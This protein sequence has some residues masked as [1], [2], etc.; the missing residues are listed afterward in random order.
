MMQF[1]RVAV[2]DIGRPGEEGIRIRNN[3]ISFNVVKTDAPDANALKVEIFNLSPETRAQVESTENRLVLSAGYAQDTIKV[4]AVGDVTSFYTESNG[5]G[6]MITV[7]E[8]GDGIRALTDTRVS[9][10]YEDGIAA[11]DIVTDIAD[12]LGVDA[13]DNLA[14]LTGTYRNGYTFAGQAKQGLDELAKRFDF[15]WS[16]QNSILQLL[17]RRTA[18]EREVVVLS[19]ETGLVGSPRPMDDVGANISANQEE[20]GIMLTCQLQPRLVPMGVV[21]VISR[22]YNGLYRITEVEHTGD[23]RSQSWL[24]TVKARSIE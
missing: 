1:D 9:I 11:L 13:V 22:D 3:R 4:L 24:S 6:D 7:I 14:D 12:S 21:E 16:I 15:D 2:V 5:S 18:D 23:T 10:S 19:P 20:P 17:P 8:A